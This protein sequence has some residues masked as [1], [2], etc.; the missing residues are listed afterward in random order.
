MLSSYNPGKQRALI[1]IVSE[2][3]GQYSVKYYAVAVVKANTVF[4][5]K[6][7]LRGKTSCHT[8]ARRTAGW[9]VPIGYLLRTRIMPAVACGNNNNDFMSASKFFNKSCVPGKDS[10]LFVDI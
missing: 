3:Y 6:T 4:N 2:Q 5:L 10:V 7:G 9:N 8:G 1:P